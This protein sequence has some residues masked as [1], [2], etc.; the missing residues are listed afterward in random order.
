M[1]SQLFPEDVQFLQRLLKAQ[2]WYSG[3]LDGDWGPKTDTAVNKFEMQSARIATTLGTFDSVSERCLHSLNL[4][5]QESARRCLRVIL[6]AGISARII[7]GTRTYVEQ[8]AL[9]KK[10]RF[11]FPG[12]VV[13]NARGGQSSHNFG[14]A[15]DIGI[16]QNGQY[17]GDSPLYDQAAEAALAAGIDGLEW[18]GN[19]KGFRD[20][21]HFQLAT[22]LTL[23][24]LRD[25]FEN[26][27]SYV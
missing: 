23:V 27:V 10:G 21:P 13:T 24:E 6:D 1:S 15:W 14:I 3:N 16:F 26:G 18:G 17:R 7:S 25:R 9:Y 8:N 22:G 19:W 11:G 4:K 20:L 12:A 5:A 2:G